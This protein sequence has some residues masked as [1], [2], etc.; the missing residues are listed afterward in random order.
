MDH[1]Q[2]AEYVSEHGLRFF[3]VI[4]AIEKC[5]ANHSQGPE[6]DEGFNL[7][8]FEPLLLAL[9]RSVEARNPTIRQ[10]YWSTLREIPLEILVRMAG[11][12]TTASQLVCEV[13]SDLV[14]R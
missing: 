12:V 3:L 11:L 7:A 2:R 4:D 5:L 9:L 1:F 6:C 10:D 13:S 8:A 14:W